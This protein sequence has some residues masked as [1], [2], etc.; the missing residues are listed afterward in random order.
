M[1]ALALALRNDSD[2]VT[3]IIHRL[4]ELLDVEWR[5]LEQAQY[6]LLPDIT[7]EKTLLEN[8]LQA[9]LRAQ[10]QADPT[11][12]LA[13]Q[14]VNIDAVRSLRTK[15]DRNNVRLTAKRDACMKR[16]R[17]GWAATKGD[18]ATSYD[19]DGDLNNKTTQTI[20]NF[21]M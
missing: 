1:T 10:K 6:D 19:Q 8:E 5:I 17:A 7:A 12:P 13:G 15:L 16:I 9:E 14:I 18:Q 20:L 2:A 4:E 3:Q 21:K 11:N